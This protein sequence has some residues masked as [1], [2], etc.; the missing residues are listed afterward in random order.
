MSSFLVLNQPV[1]QFHLK[2]YITLT[3]SMEDEQM[4]F[5]SFSFF[6]CSDLVIILPKRLPVLKEY[7]LKD[8][9]VVGP[10]GDGI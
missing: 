6:A 3:L 5:L 7:G 1:S 9:L 2:Y 4:R 8:P 10:Q